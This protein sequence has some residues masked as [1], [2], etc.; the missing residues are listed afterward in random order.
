MRRFFF[1]FGIVMACV[2]VIGGAGL[3]ALA[4][5]GMALDAESKAYI[6]KSVA[7]IADDWDAD[8]LWQRS[9]PRFRQL[10]KKDDLRTFFE[11]TREGL[12]RLVASRGAVG[13]ARISIINAVKTVT[14]NYAVDAKFEKGDAEIRISLVKDGPQWRIQGF[15]I[16]SATLT[17][18]LVGLRS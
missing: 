15:R 8:A 4:R 9:S 5:S 17:H 7:A 14:A 3:F 13:Q 1:V 11:A 6:D 12:G 2:I 18:S 16:E 10:T